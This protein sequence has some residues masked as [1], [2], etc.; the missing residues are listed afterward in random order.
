[1]TKSSLLAF[2]AI[3]L[4]SIPAIS[5]ADTFST[6]GDTTVVSP[7]DG[8]DPTAFQLTSGTI[9]Y[10]DPTSYA[11][12]QDQITSVLD[13]AN[14]T[15]L[16]ADYKMTVGTF[17]GGAPRFTLFDPSFNSAYVYWGTPTGGGGF[18]D[19]NAGGWANTGNYASLASPD[20]R[21]Y[22]NGF[23]GINQPNT[24]VTWQQFVTEAGSI[25]LSYVTLDLDGGFS[26]P[27]GQQ[28][29]TDNFTVNADVFDAPAAVPEP[30]TWAMLI[31]GF[32]GVGAMVRKARRDMRGL[33]AA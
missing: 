6:Y 9:P 10:P 28:M 3:A 13:V 20:V 15:T 19:P 7:G 24:G 14:L 30:A 5:Q 11:G 1:M 22:V 29:L 12:L 18:S 21:V 33:L 25:D 32:L 4:L 17:G 26:G 23:G 31:L 16:S 8:A 27:N 2:S